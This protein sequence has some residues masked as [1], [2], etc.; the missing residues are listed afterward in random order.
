MK[1]V[2]DAAGIA[3]RAR[4]TTIFE[5]G[6]QR[7]DPLVIERGEGVY[8]YAPDGTRYMDFN[9]I[10][11]CVNIGH[12][13]PRVAAAVAE[14]MAKVAFVSPFMVTEIRAEVGEMLARLTPPGMTKAFFTLA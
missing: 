8:L 11:M 7:V 4:A 3:E 12:G 1:T 2:L 6:T 14:Q 13:D 5:W 9:S 10:A